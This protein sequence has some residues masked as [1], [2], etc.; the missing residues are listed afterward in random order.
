MALVLLFIALPSVVLFVIVPLDIPLQFLMG[1]AMAV[2]LLALN[3]VKSYWMTI[4]LVVLSIAVSTRYLYWRTTET[5]VFSNGVEM[6][7]G[8]GLYLAEVYAW[9]I[10]V[11]GYFQ[12]ILPLERPIVALPDDTEQWPTVDVYIPTYN[13]SLTV[14]QDTVLAALNI[15]YPADKLRVYLLDDGKRPEFGAF[16]AAA[17]AGYITRNDNNHA[18]AGNLNHALKKTSGELICIFDCD[19]VSTR[20]FLQATVGQ[21]LTDPKLALV[22]T[23]HHFYSPDPFERNLATGQQVPNEGELFYGPVQQGNDYWNAA[24][25]CGS[26]AVIRRSALQETDGFAT[27]TVTEDAHTAL[28]LQRMGWNTAF[29]AVPLS[30]GLATERLSLHIGQRMR[31]ARGMTQIFRRDNPLLGR[32]LKLPQRLCYLNAMLHFQ[33]ALPRIIFLTAPMCYLMLDQNIISSSAAAIFSY[34]LPH[35]V[36]SIVTNARIQGKHRHSFWGEIYETVLAFH[37]LKPT[38]VTLVDPKRGKFNVTDKGGLLDK[39]FFDYSM[40]KPHLITLG[41]LVAAMV[42]GVIRHFWAQLTPPDPNVLIL[43]LLWATF[44]VITLMAAV[45]TAMEQRQ[46]RAATRLEVKLPAVLYFSNGRTLKGTT[47][48]IS[49]GGVRI[50]R[51]GEGGEL[52]GQLEEIE[53]TYQGDTLILPVDLM[54]VTDREVRLRF[55]TLDIPRRRELV[56]LVMGRADAWLENGPMR[57]DNPIRSLGGVLLNAFSLLRWRRRAKAI[58]NAAGKPAPHTPVVR[59]SVES[60]FIVTRLIATL[61]AIAIGAVLL[62]PLAHADAGIAPPWP[63]VLTLPRPVNAPASVDTKMHTGAIDTLR[64]D[65]LGIRDALTLRGQ[66]AEAGIAFSFSGQQVITQAQLDLHLIHDAQLPLGARL[67][68]LINDEMVGSVDL[69]RADATDSRVSLAVDPLFLVP[70]NR[71]NIRLRSDEQRCEDPATSPLWVRL[72][73]DS[74]FTFAFERL[75]FASDLATLPAPFF[76]RAQMGKFSLPFVFADSPSEASLRNAAVVASYFGSLAQFRDIDFPVS[77][78][79]LPLGNAVIVLNG[80]ERIDGIDLPDTEAGT[81]SIIENPRDPLAKLLIV[82]GGNAQQLRSA[83]LALVLNSN[84]LSGA[85][86]VASAQKPAPRVPYDA[87]SWIPSDRPVAFSELAGDALASEAV[88][89]ASM[90][91]NFRA[92]PDTFLWNGGNIPLHVHYRF[93]DGDWFDAVNSHLDIALN[94]RYLTSAPV[95]KNG[96]LEKIKNQFGWY[97]RQEQALIEVPSYLIFGQNQLDFYFNTHF[98]PDPDCVQELPER[99][100]TQINGDSRIDLTRTQHF[101]QLPNL[102]FFVGAGFPFT[103]MADLSEAAVLLPG[104]PEASEIRT[105][106]VML[107]RFGAATGYPSVA[108]DVLLG[109]ARLDAASDKDLL[110]VSGIDGRLGLESLLAG[111]A[112]R[113]DGQRLRVRAQSTVEHGLTILQGDWSQQRAAADRLLSGERQFKGLVSR[114]SP[115]NPDRVMVLALASDTDWLPRI[116]AGLNDPSVTPE[117]RGDLAFFETPERVL[118]YRAG[119]QF[120]YGDLPWTVYLRWLFSERPLVLVVLVLVS[121]ALIATALYPLLRAHV[122]RRLR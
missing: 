34:A 89:P 26:C 99:A 32:G 64:F 112:Y 111:S 49:M 120:S 37:I 1:A 77:L 75:S 10:L 41:L 40:V 5:L 28:K 87:P 27:E 109:A 90:K 72:A 104:K 30:A 92:A 36:H 114:R 33:F 19:H 106:L 98:T 35:L 6:F 121:T 39:G 17:G 18:K 2:A 15:D 24:F 118:S 76:D 29:I 63:D 81:V 11:L 95:L 116:A 14:V 84:G 52:P 61:S 47:R 3:R 115:V 86:M 23:P 78:N 25:F 13:E 85:S 48:D 56:R 83:A 55:P 50:V 71:L 113:V 103:R 43:N 7:L 73:K 105:M 38:L 108:V 62:V 21:F 59:P 79:E 69:T 94:G 45:A 110:V 57:T 20:A 122:R 12:S 100:L 80:G 93:P 74:A 46:L 44:S 53:L 65:Q 66:R 4:A 22:Q 9:I 68:V 102:S 58:A 107:G 91:L 31:W 97:T 8:I 119:E 16:A 67:D 42:I 101:A 96:V 60:G 88:A 82:R 117:I 51:D 54:G 70:Y